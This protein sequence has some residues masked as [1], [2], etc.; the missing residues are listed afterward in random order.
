MGLAVFGPLALEGVTLSPR[1]RSVLSALVLRA[2]RPVTTDELADALWGDEP[3]GTWAKQLQASVGRV[4]NAIGRDAIETTPGA[5]L[6]RIDPESIDVQRF[7][8]YAASARLHLDDD[9]AR[10]LDAAERALGLWRGTPFA[11]LP[12]WPPAVVESERLDELRMELE[13]MRVDA[14]LRLGEHTASV[15]DAERLVREAPLRERRWVLLGTALYRGGRQADALAAFRSARERLADELGAEP[16]AE[17]TELEL[18]ILRHDD[19]LELTDS[20]ATPSVACPYRGLQPFGVEDE[21]IFFGRSTDIGAALTRLSRSRFL[22]I[23]GAS[24]SG[25]SSLVRAGVVPALQRLGDRVTILAPELHLDVRI[26][27]AVWGGGHAD[28]VVVDQFEE[29]FHAGEA[30][31]DAAA[32]AISD[33]VSRGT[34]VVLVVRSDFLDDCAAHPDLAPLVAEGVHLVG[35]MSRDALR[36]AVEEP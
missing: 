4:R 11:D 2:G 19:S 31:V 13:E 18:S 28:V 24:G 27:D 3:P 14:H 17:L 20:P 30:D 8:Q 10:A 16:G 26:R 15:A 22:A 36:E 23:S 9:P 29:V 35:P 33:A 21:A 34:I 5:Y 32:R 1:E 25:K 7:E 12:S 6:L